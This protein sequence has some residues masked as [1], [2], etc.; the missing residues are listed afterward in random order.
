MIKG[1]KN[2]GKNDNSLCKI[3]NSIITLQVCVV[4][5]IFLQVCLFK[6]NCALALTEHTISS[7]HANT[8]V[9][10]KYSYLF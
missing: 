5:V 4:I 2:Y 7:S 10:M 9:Y 1:H 8:R 3:G 6:I